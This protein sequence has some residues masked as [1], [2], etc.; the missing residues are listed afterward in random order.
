MHGRCS[1]GA[2]FQDKGQRRQQGRGWPC[3][4]CQWLKPL[5]WG[6]WRVQVLEELPEGLCD[7][8]RAMGPRRRGEK[9]VAPPIKGVAAEHWTLNP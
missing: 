6:E 2:H 1:L 4:H 3:S 8:L 7:S 5:P 9:L